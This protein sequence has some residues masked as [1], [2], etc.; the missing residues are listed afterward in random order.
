MDAINLTLKFVNQTSST[1]AQTGDFNIVIFMILTLL[2]LTA[3]I[4]FKK[5]KRIAIITLSVIG[6]CLVTV[7][8]FAQNTNK[9]FTTDKDII[10]TV[11]T[12][13]AIKVE[14]CTL[15]NVS[16]KYYTTENV[17]FKLTEEAQKINGIENISFKVTGLENKDIAPGES[18]VLNFELSNIN[19]QL[20]E[21][22]NGINLY[23]ICITPVLSK[24]YK[25]TYNSG[26]TPYN[27]EIR[28]H[29][30]VDK[31]FYH[32]GDQVTIA[33]KNT[34]E[35]YGL[36]F[37]GWSTDPKAKT[38]EFKAGSTA[39]IESDM[40]LYAIWKI[41][42]DA[43]RGCQIW[44]PENSIASFEAAAARHLWAI[45]TDFRMSAD[46]QVYCIHD[47]S[48]N[49]T[50][51]ERHTHTPVSGYVKDYDSE[52]IK[53]M[54]VAAVNSP[55][56]D[57][58]DFK[59]LYDYDK[60]DERQRSIPTMDDYFRICSESGCFAF[61]EL[62]ENVVVPGYDPIIV[63]MNKCIEKY[64]MKG[65]VIISSSDFDLLSAYR[66][67]GGQDLVHLIFG[68]ATDIDKMKDLGNSAIAFNYPD[69]D[70]PIDDF[71]YQGKKYTT[72]KEIV[73]LMHNLGMQVCFRA[74]D[75]EQ[76]LKKSFELGIDYFPTNS[77]W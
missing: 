31:N 8:A 23:T 46:G 12:D 32:R 72:H 37:N 3:L 21:K 60:L 55:K 68:K 76:M 47:S 4:L 15:T 22:L 24:E 7:P 2:T 9:I 73:D 40:T 69:L 45:E 39:T 63:Q 6:I 57:Y 20:A 64:N 56:P 27:T 19:N 74:V 75:N 1:A 77:L 10:T 67:T 17:K 70:A 71:E 25:V 35:S 59:P 53:R 34:L 65:K 5:N 14:P 16:D 13:E 49:R 18:T 44:G 43:H 36:A 38:G 62:K 48:F 51:V 11:K 33:D 50:V 41:K 58:P 52:T 66:D 26:N 42:Y 28:G 30:P 54:E 29:V 61:V